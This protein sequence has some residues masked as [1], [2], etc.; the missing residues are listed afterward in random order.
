[1][2]L[3]SIALALSLAVSGALSGVSAPVQEATWCPEVPG[4]RVEC[5]TLPRP[6][7]QGRP[8]LGAVTVGYA[9]ILRRET[10]GPAKG[11][12]LVNPGGPGG[13]AIAQHETFTALLGGLLT[14][15]DLLLVDPRGVGRSGPLTCGVPAG[16]VVTES[17]ESLLRL[18]GRCADN[19]GPRAAG[20]TSAATADD[21]DAVRAALGVPKV[22][23]Y[24]ISYGTYLLPVYAQR[25]PERVQSAVF[26][27]AYP[28]GL[29]P[30]GRE[31][32]QAV[33]LTLR[34]I[35][36]RS[37]A[38]D[39]ERAVR[40]LGRVA[41]RLRAVP[42]RV[43][44]TV[45]GRSRW[46]ALTED[47][48]AQLVYSSASVA[49]GASPSEV[50]AVGR[51][52]RALRGAARGDDRELV[53]LMGEIMAGDLAAYEGMDMGIA[54]TVSCNDYP[55]PWPVAASLAERRRHF[56]R[57]VGQA[58]PGEFGAFS[59]LGF[60]RAQ[61]DAGDYCLRWPAKGT[62]RPYVSTGRF[63]DVPVLVL[64]G[65]LDGI[66]A[67]A[68]G[69]KAAAQ[70]P[71][72]VFV[73]VPNVGHVSEFEPSGCVAGVVTAFLR[74]GRTPDTSCLAAIPPVKVSG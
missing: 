39:G 73:S 47:R 7:V 18:V 14:D 4:H 64:N 33:S 10:A 52:P 56:D 41:A 59:P 16:A 11:T 43:P 19:L 57:A 15:H 25:Y 2:T 65:D 61:A 49:V 45:G 30:L 17:R 44:L 50:P 26:S 51:L 70:F 24:G 68:N 74:D 35:C 62:G 48:F 38:C 5:G 58:R 63:P 20:Y 55:R 36:E 72:G 9:R 28:I 12:I 27:A 1:M 69:R 37:G 71:R 46:V 8:D 23:L 31:S 3:T 29:D 34:R 42:A 60:A 40:D 66:T 21:L 6:L 22:M 54:A 67:E 13:Q 32:A 53:A